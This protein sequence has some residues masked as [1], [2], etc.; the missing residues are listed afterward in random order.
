[1]PDS[2]K[3]LLQGGVLVQALNEQLAVSVQ[4]AFG[5]LRLDGHVYGIDPSE[6]ATFRRCAASED[7]LARRQAWLVVAM[8]TQGADA[9]TE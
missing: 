6:D 7:V 5:R 3:H 8:W 9:H 4:R 2:P 1:M